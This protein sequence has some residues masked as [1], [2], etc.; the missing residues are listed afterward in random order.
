MSHTLLRDMAVIPEVFTQYILEKTTEK[1]ALI[2]S[3]IVM[4]DAKY[5]RLVNSNQGGQTIQMPF[6]QDLVGDSEVPQS[7]TST[8]DA[9]LTVNNI[10]SS[11]DVAGIHMRSM[12]FGSE[13]LAADVAGADPMGV[14]ATRFADFW[15]RENQKILLAQLDGVFGSNLV[16]NSGDLIKDIHATTTA[17]PSNYISANAII[18]AV[19][20]LGDRHDLVTGMLMHSIPYFK[21]VK[22]DLIEFI[23]NSQGQLKIPTYLGK[24]IFIDD[25]MPVANAGTGSLK[26]YTTYLFTDGAFALGEGTRRVPVE[27]ERRALSE[28]EYIINR[29]RFILHPIGVKWTAVSVAGVAP[30]N[31][32]CA[33]ATNWLRVY[34]KK[35]IGMIALITNG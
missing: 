5:N 33:M 15:V 28:K 9:L 31:A 11:K 23:P 18:D 13:D 8:A 16:N 25:K 34:Q 6:F 30:T 17:T 24:R 20:L 19:S 22:D 4:V 2:Q 35:N 1:S 7:S 3:G 29:R 32:E 10:T 27:T 26:A 21:L 12:S 14:I